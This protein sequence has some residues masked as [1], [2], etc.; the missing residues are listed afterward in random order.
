MGGSCDPWPCALSIAV[1]DAEGRTVYRLCHRQST[2]PGKL[3]PEGS[4]FY[5]DGRLKDGSPAS[6]GNYTMRVTADLNGQST[7]V[8]SLPFIVYE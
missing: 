4:V 1:V 5:W 7:T 3:D 2:R 8:S 6:P